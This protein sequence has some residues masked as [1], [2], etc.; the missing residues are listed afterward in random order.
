MK[1]H[2]R[3]SSALLIG[4]GI[5]AAGGAYLGAAA[6]W[7]GVV[8]AVVGVGLS[9]ANSEPGSIGVD[10]KVT[11]PGEHPPLAGL[12]PGLSRSFAWPRSRPRTIETVPGAR[13]TVRCRKPAQRLTRS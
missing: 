4:L 13:P 12:A 9:L 1:N 10:A 6:L 2:A 11:R 5:G 7:P 3:A 8:A